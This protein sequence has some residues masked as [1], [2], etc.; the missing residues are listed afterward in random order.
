MHNYIT[1]KERNDIYV[2]FGFTCFKTSKGLQTPHCMFCNTV[3]SKA[4]MKLSELQDHFKNRHS[5][6]NV[7]G[8]DVK[9]LKAK[10]IRF[11]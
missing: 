8:H 2:Q 11:E 9:P 1:E 3:F 6:A 5:E 7:S 10:T 4:N